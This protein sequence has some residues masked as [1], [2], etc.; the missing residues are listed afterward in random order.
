MKSWPCVT[1]NACSFS[2]RYYRLYAWSRETIIK[3]EWWWPFCE[4]FSDF[5]YMQ[6]FL[7]LVI[8]AEI[9]FVSIMHIQFW[10]GKCYWSPRHFPKLKI[11]LYQKAPAILWSFFLQLH[12]DLVSFDL[13]Y[14]AAIPFEQTNKQ[15]NKTRW[16]EKLAFTR[17]QENGTLGVSVRDWNES[18]MPF[19][20]V[21]LMRQMTVKIKPVSRCKI[22]EVKQGTYSLYRMGRCYSWGFLL[23]LWGRKTALGKDI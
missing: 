12:T 8:E 22:K 21:L 14:K 13:L 4:N 18:D 6:P 16:E 20:Y 10:K 23:F 1:F 15:T 3:H 5:A 2:K 7:R 19:C 17:L 11:P 9:I